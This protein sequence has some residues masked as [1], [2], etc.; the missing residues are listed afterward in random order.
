MPPEVLAVPTDVNSG[1][2]QKMRLAAGEGEVVP[3]C[4]PHPDVP[5]LSSFSTSIIRI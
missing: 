3:V 2:S 4:L 5:L 1:K